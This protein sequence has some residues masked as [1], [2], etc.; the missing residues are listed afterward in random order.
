MFIVGSQKADK[1]HHRRQPR[2]FG[3]QS[4]QG[5]L[6]PLSNP[7]HQIL[8]TN[9]DAIYVRARGFFLT[10]QY[11]GILFPTLLGRSNIGVYKV[12]NLFLLQHGACQQTRFHYYLQKATRFP[13]T[14]G[15]QLFENYTSQVGKQVS[16]KLLGYLILISLSADII[17]E[18]EIFTWCRI[19]PG[20]IWYI[21]KPSR[22]PPLIAAFIS[23]PLRLT[24][25][26]SLPDVD[27]LRPLKRSTITEHLCAPTHIRVSGSQCQ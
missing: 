25:G 1:T 20:R 19:S 6:Y 7:R 16:T 2:L 14:F 23:L 13:N 15:S 26:L 11:M 12:Y 3:T 22:A 4:V 9:N 18:H 24:T 5:R 27:T 17:I 21:G 8:T 10:G